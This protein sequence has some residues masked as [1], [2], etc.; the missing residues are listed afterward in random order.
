MTREEM[1]RFTIRA[2]EKM[3]GDDLPRAKRVFSKCSKEEMESEY[4]DSGKTRAQL[5]AE[6]EA[7]DAKVNEVIKWV[8]QSKHHPILAADSKPITSAP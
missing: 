6:F 2:L 3:R 4:G 5:L 7:Y 1:K 8:Q